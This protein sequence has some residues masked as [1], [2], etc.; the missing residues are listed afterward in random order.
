M[1][2]C[3]EIHHYDSNQT[4]LLFYTVRAEPLS[5]QYNMHSKL[6]EPSVRATCYICIS[7]LAY[8]FQQLLLYFVIAMNDFVLVI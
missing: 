7:Y 3:A 5:K 1:I 2:L 8:H 4:L 6:L